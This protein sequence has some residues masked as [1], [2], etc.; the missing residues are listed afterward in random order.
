[1]NARLVLHNMTRQASTD[2]S[3]VD[4]Y[5]FHPLL[6]E[7][8]PS[9][10]SPNGDPFEQEQQQ[11]QPTMVVTAAAV[12]VPVMPVTPRGTSPYKDSVCIPMG[13]VDTLR[14]ARLQF[15]VLSDAAIDG[16]EDGKSNRS[17]VAAPA[18]CLTGELPLLYHYDPT[19]SLFH[20]DGSRHPQFSLIDGLLPQPQPHPQRQP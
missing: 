18:A 20:D 12:A 4:V 17:G 11:Q 14:A 8:T 5:E 15:R 6:L 16:S 9:S 19:S 10:S 3:D 13:D 1:M 7:L 2:K